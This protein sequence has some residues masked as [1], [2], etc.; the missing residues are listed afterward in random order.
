M[1]T[2]E[3]LRARTDP[4]ALR[5]ARAAAGHSPSMTTMPVA[6]HKPNSKIP[7]LVPCCMDDCPAFWKDGYGNWHCFECDPV[8]DRDMVAGGRRAGE[9]QIYVI[10]GF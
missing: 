4:A 1:K 2:A 6:H 9:K 8:V 7:P 5:A 3:D 10:P